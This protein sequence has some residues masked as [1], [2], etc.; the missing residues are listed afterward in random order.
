MLGSTSHFTFLPVSEIGFLFGRRSGAALRPS[1]SRRPAAAEPR[2]RRQCVPEASVA[3]AVPLRAPP[4]L[5]R[6][7]ALSPGWRQGLFSI[8]CPPLFESCQS[9]LSAFSPEGKAFTFSGQC[10]PRP[11]L[12]THLAIAV[13]P[14]EHWPELPRCG[15]PVLKFGDLFRCY[16]VVH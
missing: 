13:H 9:N 10:P 16:L 3:A 1:C 6:A 11:P 4:A 8:C 14:G 2:P 7:A 5:V 15:R 12:P